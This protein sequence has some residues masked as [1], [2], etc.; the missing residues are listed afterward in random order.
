VRRPLLRWAEPLRPSPQHGRVEPPPPAPFPVK[1]L[2]RNLLTRPPRCCPHCPSV[3]TGREL[4]GAEGAAAG[5]SHRSRSTPPASPP[6]RTSVGI[7]PKDPV[8]PPPPS[9]GRS[10]PP[11]R[12]N[13]AGPLPA[14]TRGPNC[15]VSILSEGLSANQGHIGKISNLSRDPV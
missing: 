9:P 5:I 3:G 13:L 6:P 8:G 7:E 15:E 1:E 2:F 14:S 11:V 10:R 12:P 4:A